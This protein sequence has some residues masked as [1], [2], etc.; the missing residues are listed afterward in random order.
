MAE[1]DRCTI[2]VIPVRELLSKDA[3]ELQLTL[4][5]GEE[6]TENPVRS[7]AVQ[8]PGLALAGFAESIHASSIQLLEESDRTFL[9]KM[10]GFERT[11][12]L[13]EVCKRK[14]ACFI[15][16]DEIEIPQ[17]LFDATREH[18][19]PILRTALK[20]ALFMEKVGNFLDDRLSPRTTVHGVLLDIY[21]LGVLILGES[22]V[23][24]S[25]CALDLIVRGHR[26][27]SD[28][29]VEIRR[30]EDFLVGRGP[31]M[32]RYH[33]ELRGLG[34][35]NIKDLF[36]ITSVRDEKNVEYV[37]GLDRWK[38]GK[39]Y[40]RL[41]LEES[42]YEILGIDLPYSEMPVAP[43]RN[44]SVL[45]EVAARNQ[46][47][48]TRGDYSARKLAERLHERLDNEAHREKEKKE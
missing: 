7:S 42:S 34:I 26:L 46:L 1:K 4:V 3:L 30:K 20:S 12:I 8:K 29:A 9:D 27:V 24:K 38:D 21:G 43:G 6:F 47:L 28:D 32:T 45:I 31:E 5:S 25:E 35:I 11:A 19:I 40:D 14:V 18:G 36:G 22:G 44:L 41:G 39:E 15:C 10:S 17:E 33:M 48:K 16:T 13:K 2:P 23:G 37:V